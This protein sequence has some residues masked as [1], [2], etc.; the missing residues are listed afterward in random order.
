M[1]P[2]RVVTLT[3]LAF[4]A[5]GVVTL[6]VKG[7]TRNRHPEAAANPSATDTS[8]RSGGSGFQPEGA[9]DRQDLRATA[10]A[11]RQTDSTAKP[12][13]DGVIAYYFHGNTRCP[14]CQTIESYAHDAVKTGFAD[15]L[16]SG[17]LQW[18]VV[19]YEAA[20]NEHFAEL[21]QVVAPTVVLVRMEG[22]KPTRWA[23]LMRVWELVGD[24][25]AFTEYIQTE[26]RTLL[27]ESGG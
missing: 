12:P 25:D 19:N 3:L 23:N 15:E 7:L 14:T 4:V 20:G 24:Q 16:A 5:A 18:E 17:D 22:G 9:A 6:A 8:R 27:G 10:D 1:K 11:A 13:S 26:T 21:Y 2:K